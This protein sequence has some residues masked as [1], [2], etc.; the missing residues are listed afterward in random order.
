MK[1]ILF[2]VDDTL[3]DQLEPFK[4]AYQENFNYQNISIEMLYILSRKYSDEVFHLSENGN[5]S[6]QEMHMY[7]IKKALTFFGYEITNE[8][9]QVFQKDY[10]KHQDL[11]ELKPDMIDALNY[12]KR[13]KIILGIITNGPMSHQRKKIKR[14]QLEQWIPENHI[15][16]SSEVGVAKPNSRIF[17]IA[18]KKLKLKKEDTYFVGDSIQND[19][20]GAK[21]VGWKTIWSNDRNKSELEIPVDPDFIINEKNCLTKI[22]HSI[23]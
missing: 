14:L 13:K 5:M 3:Y 17:E 1:A 12:C 11:I 16:I 15:F 21:S 2:D 10:E 8:E 19:I 7:R 22:L 23:F 18:E 9:A 6:M 20:V 4:K